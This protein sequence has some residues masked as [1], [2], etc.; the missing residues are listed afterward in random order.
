MQN[1]QDTSGLIPCEADPPATDAQAI[2]GGL[3][4]R[5]LEHVALTGFRKP[6]DGGDNPFAGRSIEPAEVPLGARCPLD[7]QTHESPSSRFSSSVVRLFP[8]L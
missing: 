8:A 3:L 4:A 1:D 6:E 2:F 5:E 7:A